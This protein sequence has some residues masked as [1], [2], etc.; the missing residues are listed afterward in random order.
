MQI[1]RFFPRIWQ[2]SVFFLIFFSVPQ[3]GFFCEAGV[4]IDYNRYWNIAVKLA[5]EKRYI[6]AD[7]IFTNLIKKH[8][9]DAYLYVR[10]GK[11]RNAYMAQHQAAISD[12]NIALKFSIVRS[13]R[14][15][16]WYKGMSEY[17]LGLYGRAIKSY[18]LALKLSPKWAKLYLFRAKAYGKLNMID[19]V[20]KDLELAIKYQPGYQKYADDIWKKVTLGGDF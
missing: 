17:E 20:K 6:E 8:P 2:L 9:R 14:G 12:F 10:R 4:D 3:F 7:Q 18:S 5:K 16:Y 1:L 15:V 11:L 13:D 19:K